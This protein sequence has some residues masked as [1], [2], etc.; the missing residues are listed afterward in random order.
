MTAKQTAVQHPGTASSLA[1][2][3]GILMIVSGLLILTVSVFVLPA[4]SSYFAN[5][6]HFATA[7]NGSTTAVI[8]NGTTHYFNG[9][10]RFFNGSF[11]FQP[12]MIPSFVSGITAVVG[13]FGLVSGVIVLMSGVLLRTNPSQHTV[14]GVLVLVFSVL[15]FFGFGGFIIGAILG[16]IG[17]IMALTWKPSPTPA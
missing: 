5:N 4:M 17:G 7:A 8:V 6:V 12:S 10:N 14:W 3:G 15:S 11:P 16:I 2:A 1:I 13:T 9:T